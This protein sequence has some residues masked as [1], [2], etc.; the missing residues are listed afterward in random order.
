MRLSTVFAFAVLSFGG[1]ANAL[2]CCHYATGICPSPVSPIA[3]RT[4]VNPQPDGAQTCCTCYADGDT[5]DTCP[6]PHI[7]C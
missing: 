4:L 5:A 7:N 2:Y 1:A 3:K 6:T